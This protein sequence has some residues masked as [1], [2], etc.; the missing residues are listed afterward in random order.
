[1]GL[2]ISKPVDEKPVVNNKP[3]I[4]Y[5][6]YKSLL[7]ENQNLKSDHEALLSQVGSLKDII[8]REGKIINKLTEALEKNIEISKILS[9]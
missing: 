2:F 1:M 5:E 6:K 8:E 9:E 3:M 7:I 4:D